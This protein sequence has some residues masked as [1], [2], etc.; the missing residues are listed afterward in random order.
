VRA[1]LIAGDVTGQWSLLMDWNKEKRL[2]T[3]LVTKPPIVEAIDGETPEDL[4]I[5]FPIELEEEESLETEEVEEEGP[6]I[7]IIPVQDIAVIP[8]TENNLQ[9]AKAVALRLR[10]T[11]EMVEMKVDEGV[12]VLPEG[13]TV[14][15]FCT[16]DKGKDKRPANK[17]A[18]NDA[19]IRLEGTY[20]YALIYMVYC[21]LPFGGKIDEEAIVYFATSTKII[22]LIK[23][24]LW[25][26]KRPL[27]SA[28]LEMVEGSFYG[29]S[30]IE[31]V[32]F[33]QWQICDFWNMMQDSAT[34]TTLPIFAADPMSNPMWQM[35]TISPGA[36]WPIAPSAVE[37]MKFEP[38]WG[39]SAPQL[40]MMKAQVRES[41]DVND[42][43]MGK[44]PPGRKNNALIGS[45]Q[46]EQ[47]TNIGDVA[48]RFEEEV[49]DPLVEMIF[50]FDQQ[51]RTNNLVI[52]QRGEIGYKATIQNIPPQQWGQRYIFRWTGTD[53]MNSLQ[54]MQQ[55]TAFINVVKGTP[56]Q[57][58]GKKR[59]DVTPMLEDHANNLFGPEMGPR[60]LVDESNLYTV[61]AEV[62][63]EIL[64]ND[65]PVD[66]H[67]GDDDVAHLQVHIRGANMAA[68]GGHPDPMGYRKA[69]MTAHMESLKKKREKQMGQQ[70]QQGGM[71]GSPGGMQPGGGP[72][73]GIAGAPRP[74][75][76]PA[77]GGPRGMQNPPGAISQDAMPGAPGR[78]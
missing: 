60:I 38:M 65:A 22:G 6:D 76:V 55:Q 56:P 26:G 72:A 36:V 28:P 19:G 20:K 39:K 3:K 33:T 10:M 9:K 49:L 5:E 53:F 77:P 52:E 58:M 48:E 2:I 34:Y 51:F 24:P 74:G 43:M 68:T 69:H 8:P 41:M 66:I 70:Q 71:P 18:V 61:P 35:M 23:N 15:A 21:K 44:S 59:L 78:G 50:E 42:A 1:A 14:E 11:P 37:Q 25:S 13:M 12:F 67:E 4:D 64:W 32:K 73:P 63:E 46:Q 7:A 45:M 40:E 57:M 62:E 54:R 75:A 17:K 30:K 27:I 16:P 31:P 47:A 29:I